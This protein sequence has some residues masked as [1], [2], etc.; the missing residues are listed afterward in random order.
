MAQTAQLTMVDKL[1]KLDASMTQ[2]L[3][4]EQSTSATSMLGQTVKATD[5][6][7]HQLSGTVTGVK[8]QA[9]GPV[10]T[11]NGTDIPFSSV[12]EVDHP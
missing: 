10:L 11:V 12:T 5:S 9:T 3:S 8:L 6:S 2:L 4:A 7:G 1:N